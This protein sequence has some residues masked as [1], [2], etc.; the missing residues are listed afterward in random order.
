MIHKFD[1]RSNYNLIVHEMI[2][3]QHNKMAEHLMMRIDVHV[4]WLKHPN[5]ITLVAMANTLKAPFVKEARQ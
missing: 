1:L 4:V 5:E 2:M 3:I